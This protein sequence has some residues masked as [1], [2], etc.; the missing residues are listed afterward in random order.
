M[1]IVG[2][3]NQV[4]RLL[5]DNLMSADKADSST[6]FLGQSLPPA[7]DANLLNMDGARH[8]RVRSLAQSAFSAR[9]LPAQREVVRK[10]AEEL[11]ATLPD[12]GWIDLVEDWCEPFPALVIG[13]LL[14]LPEDQLP[15]FQAAARPMFRIDTSEAGAGIRDSL[16]QMLMLVMAAVEGK[17]RNPG[18]DLLS[19][20]IAARD[21]TD[22]LTE[23]ELISL[24]FATIIG[25]FENVT[26]LISAVLADV[27]RRPREPVLAIVGNTAELSRL[28]DEAIEVAA[29]V[30][31]ALRRFPLA[32]LQVG[33]HSIPRG[34]TVVLALRSANEDPGRKGRPDVVFGYGRHS[35]PGAAL[36]A[37]E[38]MESIR[39]LMKRYTNLKLC[40]ESNNQSFKKSWATQSLATL[41]VSLGN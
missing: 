5:A 32:D 8:R 2:G 21:G 12:S 29:P 26:A 11:V 22:K 30:N 14:G 38:V 34:E 7:L 1:W 25:G 23:E 28:V 24:A 20:W 33:E 17:R 9:R 36:A 40:E 39:V 35:C 41:Q 27:L 15:A 18:P 13:R 31:Y 37:S 16:G 3:Y 4:T 10:T 19:D 6:G